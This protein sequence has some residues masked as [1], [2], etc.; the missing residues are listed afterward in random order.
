MSIS[1]FIFCGVQPGYHNVSE[2]SPQTAAAI[3]SEL[4]LKKD[5]NIPVYGGVAI[6]PYDRGCPIG[7]EPVAAFQLHG[8]GAEIL[9][10]ADYLRIQ[11]AQA[12]VNVPIPDYG[13]PS[14]GFTA[15]TSGDIYDMGC[16]WQEIAKKYFL[17]TAIH[18]S[19]GIVD[20][21]NGQLLLSA[22]ANPITIP[23]LDLWKSIALNIFDELNLSS[24]SFQTV[25]YN[26]IPPLI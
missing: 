22:D 2:F 20:L 24:P 6:Y 12:T 13:I 17:L 14:L 18:V 5:I 23:D 10:T 7:G 26:F 9:R 16:A 21:G 15:S 4:L 19:M 11:L 8:N 1:K 3:V 25:G